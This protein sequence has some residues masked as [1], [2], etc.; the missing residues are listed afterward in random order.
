[1]SK[2]KPLNEYNKNTNNGV[3]YLLHIIA[4]RAQTPELMRSYAI[5]FRNLCQKLNS[6]GCEDHCTMMLEQLPPENY[7]HILDEDGIPDGCLRHSVECHNLVNK[8]LN[9]SQHSY[10]AVKKLYRSKEVPKPCTKKIS[11]DGELSDDKSNQNN[12][13]I[14]KRKK[15]F[16]LVSIGE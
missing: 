12:H 4:E 8:R 3:W 13:N 10:E 2:S 5:N 7:F 9:K 14:I 15:N 6:C 16:Y 1:M 11:I